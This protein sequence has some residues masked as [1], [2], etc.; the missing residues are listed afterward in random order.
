M[1][2]V[3]KFLSLFLVL[4][5]VLLPMAACSSHEEN[6]G[7]GEERLTERDYYIVTYENSE[8]G[9]IEGTLVQNVKKGGST[10]NVTA[11]ADDGYIFVGWSDGR[12]VATRHD[13][14]VTADITVHPVFK[15]KGSVFTVTYQL[16]RDGITIKKET[17]KGYAGQM[18]NYTAP[19]P[20]IAYELVW[21]DSKSENER[22]DSALLDGTVIVGEYRPI[23]FEAPIITINTDSGEDITS[24]RE[25]V[26]CKVGVSNTDNENCFESVSAK[27]RGRGNSSWDHHD[28][29]SFRIKFDKKR[30]MLGSDYKSKSWT[31]IANHA[32]GTL[33][34][35]ALAYELSSRLDDIAFTTTHKY[36][37]VFLNGK[38]NGTYLLCDQIQTGK[39]RVD[40]EE[41][42][43]GDPNTGYFILLDSRASWDGVEDLNYFT[44]SNDRPEKQYDMRTPDPDD[45]AYDPNVYMKYIQNYMNEALAA[46]SS[47]DWNEIC[48]FIEPDTFADV[49]IINELFFNIDCGQLSFYFYK[50]KDG[51]LCCGPVWD[52]DLSLGNSHYGP[53]HGDFNPPDA[54]IQK[55]GKL[56]AAEQ[57]TW[58]RRLLRTD[59]F[60]EIVKGK[61]KKYDS[62]IKDIIALADVENE[63]GYYNVYKKAINR[64]FERWNILGQYVW[65]N[66][67]EVYKLDSVEKHFRF[68]HDWI[69]KRYEIIK[70]Y[71]E[72]Q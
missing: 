63:N 36:V 44:L 65:P 38:Y 10:S 69:N 72:I 46:L 53:I 54:D 58:F 28:K 59:E 43:T 18:I 5:C 62:V 49:Y 30:S 56:W 14:Y 31:L 17:I 34:R 37:E 22:H 2:N 40:V 9:R 19:E 48:R 55:S 1:R 3:N 35:N 33:S 12:T 64:N 66:P 70:K 29:K 20:S 68:A 67:E 11:I 47:G 24:K 32:D 41:K 27:I 13:A 16:E 71:Y 57:N 7:S 42:L 4:L 52:F 26:S 25:Y 61:L 8:N 23:P 39:G 50:A 15:K 51:K 21:S 6:A 45:P 60:R